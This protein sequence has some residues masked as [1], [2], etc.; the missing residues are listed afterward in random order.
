MPSQW[1]T[2]GPTLIKGVER[3]NVVIMHSQQ[4]EEV[5]QRNSYAINIDRKRNYYTYSRF[6]HM[7]QHC[8]NKR[9]RIKVGDSRRLEYEQWGREEN[10]EY[11]DNL[12]KRENLESL[13]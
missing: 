11:R 13:N 8:R 10:N 5:A 1:A 3:T 9:Q 2:T 12:K 6:G 4:R 7:A